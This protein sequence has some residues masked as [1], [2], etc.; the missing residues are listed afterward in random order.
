M[1][2]PE[3]VQSAHGVDYRYT[4]V[5]EM[6]RLTRRGAVLRWW[7]WI[8]ESA[9]WGCE[10]ATRAASTTCARACRGPIWG[11]DFCVN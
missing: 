10:F 5:G 4:F 2:F 3:Y 11:V 1:T 6:Q 8:G 9:T 7:L